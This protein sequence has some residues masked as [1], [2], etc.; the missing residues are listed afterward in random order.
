MARLSF[1]SSTRVGAGMA[2]QTDVGHAAQLA[3]GAARLARSAHAR[4]CSLGR[5]KARRDGSLGSANELI[6]LTMS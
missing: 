2:E 3:G 1:F 6:L 5:V 4:G